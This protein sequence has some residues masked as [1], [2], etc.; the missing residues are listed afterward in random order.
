MGHYWVKAGTVFWQVADGVE[1]GKVDLGC[2]L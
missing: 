1:E 2:L